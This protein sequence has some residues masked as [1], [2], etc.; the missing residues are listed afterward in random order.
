MRAISRLAAGLLVMLVGSLL[1]GP[2]FAEAA[3]A[4]TTHLPDLQTIIPTTFSVVTTATGKEF[5]Y[6]HE[7]FSAGPGPFS[8]QP[9]YSQ[10]SGNYV[11][12]Q[13]LWTHNASGQW[14]QTG[15]RRIPDPFIFHAAHGHFHFPLA[16]FGLYAV[17]ADGGFGAPVTL[18][19]K[20]GFCIADSYMY[21]T[22]VDHA[23]TFPAGTIGSC[24]DPLSLR[25]MTTGAV[26]EYDYRDPGQAIPMDGVPNGTYWF[27][28]ITDPNNDIR[29]ADESNNET[30]VKVVV[31]G[32]TVTAGEVRHPDTT[33]PQVTLSSPAAG[34]I[35]KGGAVK[36]TAVAG[37]GALVQFLVDGA[38]VGTAPQGSAPY[39]VDWDSRTVVEGE[40]WLAARTIDSK[41]YI[42]TTEVATVFVNNAATPPPTGALA[43]DGQVSA[44]G[45]GKVTT[46]PLS[47]LTAGDL[48]VA[49][50]ASDGAQGQ[51]VTVSG[52]GLNWQLVRRVNGRPGTSE[53]WRA[54]APSALSG[55]TFTST[56][57][58]GSAH[59]SIHVVAFA[60]ATGLGAS[61]GASAASG[62]PK[63]SVTT[64]QPGSWVWGVGNDWDR[65][66]ARTAAAGQTI[67]HQWVDS[68]VGDTFWMQNMSAPTAAG[69][70]TV[71]LS[72]TAPT[73]DQ[74]NYAAA[75]VLAGTVVAPP[76]DT[77]P[78]LVKMTDPPNGATVSGILPIAATASDDVGVVRVQFK[79]DGQ[80]L[81]APDTAPPFSLQWDSRTATQG[82]HVLSADAYDAAGNVGTSAGSS[83]VVDNSAPQAGV[84]TIDKSVSIHAKSTL[85]APALTTSE[86]GEQL[87]AFVSQDGPLGTAQ[88]STVSGGGLTWTLVKRSNTQAGTSEVWTARAN[89]VLNAAVIKAT[90]SRTGY[91]GLL[92]VMAFK[93]A[94][95]TAVAGAAGA[96]TGAPDIYLPGIQT[97]SW[98]FA[99]GNDWDRAVARTPVSGQVLQHQWIDS[100]AG[101]TFWVQSLA[102]PTAAPGLVTIHDN[103]P[104]TDR[105]NY[106]AVELVAAP[107]GSGAG[108]P[109]TTATASAARIGVA[110]EARRAQ[111]VLKATS[112][113]DLGSVAALPSAYDVRQTL[114]RDAEARIAA[115]RLARRHAEPRRLKAWKEPALR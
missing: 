86:A 109:A 42:N 7:V 2:G 102:A 40:H 62:A 27:R 34:A 96:A 93:G 19:P 32:P 63:V 24:A 12:N 70:T 78:P 104:T 52:G 107:V 106:A 74:Y 6:T 4:G 41:G 14:S 15:T 56:Q 21:D 98:V 30:D 88:T 103:A 11:G 95:G 82:T 17:A 53:I 69:G 112:L 72:D 26:D 90:P 55:A 16:A 115:R 92:H 38:V 5:R 9:E 44:D 68:S 3:P 60:N 85:T 46:G 79:L 110:A 39:S 83:V 28:A 111:A 37:D 76:A 66:V 20:N 80:P 48:V 100:A 91:D 49:F 113:C 101:D 61:A 97:G 94:S 87:L 75:E 43:V 31:N 47:T 67:G 10:S 99:V 33:P 54:V 23:G 36:L 18:S 77:S 64:S 45:A 57:N 51:T 22:T 108:A 29:E 71:T 50:V 1:L 58:G 114:A 105:W 8:I 13:Q 89:T 81:G 59:Q 84:I 73:T 25:G 65:A 35:V